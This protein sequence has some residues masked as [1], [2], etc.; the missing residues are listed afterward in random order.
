MHRHARFSL[1]AGSLA[2]ILLA[3]GGGAADVSAAKG[4][5]RHLRHH[6]PRCT[7]V[8]RHG[9]VVKRHGKTVMRCRKRRAS[10]ASSTG[11]V[12]FDAG[13]NLFEVDGLGQGRR[14]L[15]QA[16]GA[17]QYTEP[18]LSADGS[19]MVFQGPGG[20]AYSAD[21]GAG[22]Q[23]VMSQG[24]TA[25]V[26]PQISAD[27]SHVMWVTTSLL[28]FGQEIT[29]TIEGSDGSNVHN[30]TQTYG[31]A[32]FAPD[33]QVFC[34]GGAANVL[35]V[36]PDGQVGSGSQCQATV[37]NDSADPK[38]V[39]GARPQFS[40]DGSLVADSISDDGGWSSTGI[41]IYDAR[42]GQLAG[43]LTGGN[44]SDPVFSPDGSKILFDRGADI[45]EVPARGG[46]ATLFVAG[47]QH[48]TWSR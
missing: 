19:R 31:I 21:G 24:P 25:A 14:Q 41:Y 27:G 17:I 2:A 5:R 18:S 30:Y 9:Q 35:T 40:P 11:K 22:H 43:R 47:G 7:P 6:K 23:R 16:G 3:L 39:F 32:G 26:L 20:Q 38:A 48:P 1:L 28:L 15:T 29:N 10:T 13:G 46:A 12:I 37:A 4:H 44:D 34:N 33:G 45:Y 36:A 8:R 42:T